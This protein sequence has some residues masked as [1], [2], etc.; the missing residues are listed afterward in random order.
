M[1]GKKRR[2]NPFSFKM[3]VRGDCFFGRDDLLQ[4][5]FKHIQNGESVSLVGEERTGKTSILLRVLDLKEQLISKSDQRV[6][7]D[8]L[9]LNYSVGKDIIWISILTELSEEMI[10]IGL[11]SEK[12]V[13]TIE[14]L[15]SS[16]IVFQSPLRRLFRS[17]TEDGIRVT[18]LF[19]KFE[20]ILFTK[21]SATFLDT[22][23]NLAIAGKNLSYVIATCPEL[24][25]VEEKSLGQETTSRVRRVHLLR[26]LNQLTV[27]PLSRDEAQQ[28]VAELLQS[29]GLNLSTKLN[30]WFHQDLLFQLSGFYP[31]YLQLACYHLFEHCVLPDGTFTD[32]I[33]FREIEAD[34][35]SEAS[36]SFKWYWIKSSPEEQSLM[37]ELAEGDNDIDLSLRRSTINH[38]KHRGLVMNI[39]ADAPSQWRLFSSA[40]ARW[41]RVYGGSS[42]EPQVTTLDVLEALHEAYRV[43]PGEWVNSE[44]I[45]KDLGLNCDQINDIIMLLRER[46]F[47]E[48]KFA[49]NKSLLRITADGV[50]LI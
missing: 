3:P 15:R 8:L 43:E 32:Q 48:A 44:Q 33:H 40:F 13:D 46:G 26:I 38:L 12:V 11:R 35:L 10:R 27:P 20:N 29:A 5:I 30:F 31:F 49:D 45:R 36:A 34:F 24:S 19:D 41:I 37:R 18:F 14:R 2:S 17:L 4:K 1:K 7:V 23:H 22:L 6:F 28:M 47:I 39:D 42:V 16:K 9:G 25:E 21:D 50:K